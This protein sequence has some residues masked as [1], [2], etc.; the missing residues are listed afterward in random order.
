[1]HVRIAWEIYN[2]QQKAKTDA[3]SSLNPSSHSSNK[4]GSNSFDLLNKTGV[5]PGSDYIG[6]RP[7]PPQDLLRGH[8][9]SSGFPPAPGSLGLTPHHNPFDPRDPYAQRYAQSYGSS[10]LAAAA[11]SPYNRYPT[12]AAPAPFGG[13]GGIIPSPAVTGSHVS[14]H[15]SHLNSRGAPPHSLATTTPSSL[16]YPYG[17][18]SGLQHPS[19]QA[20]VNREKEERERA[21]AERRAREKKEAEERE[22]RHREEEL[23]ATRDSQARASRE[24]FPAYIRDPSVRNGESDNGRDRSPVRPEDKDKDRRMSGA[25]PSVRPGE[26]L[27]LSMPTNLSSSQRQPSDLSINQ[28]G[29]SDLSTNHVSSRPGSVINQIKSAS[30]SDL[31]TKKEERI[32]DDISIIAEKEGNRSGANSVTGRASVNSD[33]SITRLNGLDTNGLK[34]DSPAAAALKAGAHHLP[35]AMPPGGHQPHSYLYPGSQS[36]PGQPPISTS[37]LAGHGHPSLAPPPTPTHDPRTLAMYPHIMGQSLRPPNPLDPY[38]AAAAATYASMD[39]Y[40]DPFRLDLLGRDP[41]REAR[42]RELMRLGAAAGPL[43]TSL[44]LERAKA[45]S[46][47]SAGFH[48]PSL[49]AGA[50][51]AYPGYPTSAQAA[52]SASLAAHKMGVP[53]HLSSL[54]PSAA[55]PA[56][57]L[58]PSLAAA[59][60]PSALGYPTAGLNGAVPSQYGKDPLRR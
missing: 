3:K 10:P 34:S 4:L 38:A 42:E 25:S 56:A 59:G 11:P 24:G 44:E 57:A 43:G 29:P 51:A 8:N 21:E 14:P 32:C 58:H 27:D 30:G 54:Y 28:R 31:L 46:L 53:S 17:S 37:Y 23:Q 1:M 50:A 26:T 47:S 40:R 16:S 45:L 9:P 22:R 39:P 35:P 7:G 5:A 12:S 6:K 20:T 36:R 33:H 49:A 15:V 60:Y 48:H 13:L 52:A 2:H 55:N 18:A 41:L 19:H